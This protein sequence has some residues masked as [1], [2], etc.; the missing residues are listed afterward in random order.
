MEEDCKWSCA[1]KIRVGLVWK[2]KPKTGFKAVYASTSTFKHQF[3]VWN[4]GFCSNEFKYRS[5]C[6]SSALWL[7]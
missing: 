7:S 1:K 2:T 5:R 3:L 6:D 4:L